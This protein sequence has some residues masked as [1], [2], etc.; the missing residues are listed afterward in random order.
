MSQG[1]HCPSP[2]VRR[3]PRCGRE[4]TSPG[5]VMG[6]PVAGRG[7]RPGEG[8][9]WSGGPATVHQGQV[10]AGRTKPP[11]RT[12]PRHVALSVG[13]GVSAMTDAAR[14][15][16]RDRALQGHEA[17]AAIRRSTRRRRPRHGR[18]WSAAR[19]QRGRVAARRTP[20]GRV[21]RRRAQRS[22]GCSRSRSGRCAERG[23]EAHDDGAPLVV[24]DV[25]SP[26]SRCRS[27]TCSRR[28]TDDDV[29]FADRGGFETATTSTPRWSSAIIRDE[30]GQGEGANLVIGRH[31]RAGRR[32]LG[33][34]ARR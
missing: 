17:W 10:R 23:F 1:P 20:R 9:G 16:G 24:V 29:E 5:H 33:T 32:R 28:S 30:I 11:L 6:P 8:L 22:T 18:R 19:A 27:T 13:L 2:T 3:R 15:P 4:P 25:A 26:S 34:P 12:R 31:Y 14:R 21:R 7:G